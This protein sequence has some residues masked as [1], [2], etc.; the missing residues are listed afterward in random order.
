MESLA[1]KQSDLNHLKNNLK[2]FIANSTKRPKNLDVKS[3]YCNKSLYSQPSA[4]S[5]DTKKN[6]LSLN[7]L[8]KIIQIEPSP[9]KITFSAR[10]CFKPIR[11][12]SLNDSTNSKAVRYTHKVNFIKCKSEGMNKSSS[13]TV[14]KMNLE[15]TTLT[16]GSFGHEAL[17]NS[18][19]ISMTT[20]NNS[21][22]ASWRE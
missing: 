15:S 1:N 21:N 5:L 9:S 19:D 3:S 18:C 2:A 13:E 17:V 4:R 20:L 6:S 8:E 22:S 11:P 10:S 7:S 16:N 14:Q 12:A